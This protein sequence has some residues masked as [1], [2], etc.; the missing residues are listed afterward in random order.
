MAVKR[1]GHRCLVPAVCFCSSTFTDAIRGPNRTRGAQD[2][3][4]SAATSSLARR[5]GCTRKNRFFREI[6]SLLNKRIEQPASGA[7]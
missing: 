7:C 2:L 1:P 3:F 5:S 6:H 4:R